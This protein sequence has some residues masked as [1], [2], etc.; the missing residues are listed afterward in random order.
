MEIVEAHTQPH[1]PF[2]RAFAHTFDFAVDRCKVFWRAGVWRSAI[3]KT[4]VWKTLANRARSK[5][6]T[7]AVRETAALGDRR[8]VCVIQFERQRFLVG[9]SPSSVTLLAQLPDE[10]ASG[11]G[12]GKESGERN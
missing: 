1:S 2:S 5:R 6:K 11:D 9:S 8:F 4:A 12:S 7:L 3:W 10:S